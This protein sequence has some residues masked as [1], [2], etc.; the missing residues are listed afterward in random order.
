[1]NTHGSKWIRPKK[2]WAIY[3]R[4]GGVCAYCGVHAVDGGDPVT[5]TLDHLLP[6]E[7]GGSND[8]TNLVTACLSCN[9]AR[10]AK[11]FRAW[12]E[13]LRKR[14]TDTT[15]LRRRIRRMVKKPLPRVA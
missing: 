2:R 8:A 3:K 5:F 14:G 6:R 9:S 13:H 1:M 12:L 10:Q 4:D 15:K 7:L 11:T